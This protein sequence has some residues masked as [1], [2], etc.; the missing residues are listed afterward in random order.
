MGL[1]QKFFKVVIG[2]LMLKITPLFF[3]LILSSFSLSSVFADASFSM[4]EIT[5]SLQTEYQQQLKKPKTK[6]RIKSKARTKQSTILNRKA[7]Q[8]L[9]QG[10]GSRPQAKQARVSPHQQPARRATQQPP[11]RSALPVP[12]ANSLFDAA[13]SGNVQLI[14]QLLR[15]GANINAANRERE[16]ALHIAAARGQYSAVIYLVN[17]GA[18]LHARTIKNWLPI[19]HATRFQHANIANYLKQR[20][21]SPYARTSDGLSAIDM[22][23]TLGD[24]RLLGI[25]GGK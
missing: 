4:D 20:G 1:N 9:L 23:R 19:H 13:A 14:G 17:H 11:K 18:N 21:A 12:S 7:I 8:Q 16:T 6:P 22:A 10:S 3:T 25:F 2:Y 5:Q 15:R 24:R